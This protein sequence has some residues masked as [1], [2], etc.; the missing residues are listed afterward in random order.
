MW[1]LCIPMLQ[2]KEEFLWMADMGKPTIRNRA[3]L[4]N[5]GRKIKFIAPMEI[6]FALEKIVQDYIAIQQSD[7]ATSVAKIFGYN[8][9]TE[10]MREELPAVLENMIKEN[11]VKKDGQLI[12][13]V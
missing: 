5:S 8:C 7:A 3:N 4:A 12:K 2:I 1:Q 13:Q 9:V 11:V 6:A 10:D